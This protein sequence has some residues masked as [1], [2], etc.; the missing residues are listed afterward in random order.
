M[1]MKR[2]LIFTLLLLAVAF[3]VAAQKS[4][5]GKAQ[6]D[7][8]AGEQITEVTL[9]RTAC[10]GPCPMYTIT[11]RRDGT[12]TY[13]GR[14]YTERQG[15]YTGNFY[16]F[17]RLAQFIESKGYFKL[18]DKYS[19]PITDAPG[20]IT[21]VVRAGRRKTVNNYADSG[22]VELFAIEKAIDGMV[23]NTKWVKTGDK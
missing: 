16:G 22:P 18:K 7:R 9:E 14:K 5:D 2:L 19:T 20:T 21:S 17:Q 6:E 23:A 1:M 4:Q 11:L 13:V 10:F 15:T 3:N 8:S 12:A